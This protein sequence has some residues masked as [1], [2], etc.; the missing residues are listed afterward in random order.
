VKSRLA[1]YKAPRHVV[2]VDSVGRAANGKT[3]Y[4]AI[5]ALA[6]ERLDGVTTG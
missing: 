5:R 4:P 1:R 3:D 2:R 6:L